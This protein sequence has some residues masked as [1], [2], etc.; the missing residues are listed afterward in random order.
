[1]P[2]GERLV[3][4]SAS[5]ILALF[6]L[7][8]RADATLV[9]FEWTP[10][11]I[12]LGADSLTTKVGTDKITHVIQCKIHQAGDIFF[13]IIGVND[14]PALKVDLVSV[15]SQAARAKGPVEEKMAS[16]EVLAKSQI[17]RV[18]RRGLTIQLG[19]AEQRIDIIFVDRK[20]H[21]LVLKEYVRNPDGS[22]S[23]LP[24][25][26]Y[27][28][29]GRARDVE[30]VGVS[31]EAEAALRK[32]PSLLK[33]QGADFI[34][35]FIQSQIDHERYRLRALQAMPRVGGRVCVLRIQ[36][37]VASWVSGHQGPCP[38]IKPGEAAQRDAEKN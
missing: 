12:L 7:P 11:E 30:A 13:T 33:L 22:T 19:F 38:D 8:F 34:V 4:G 23:G 1:M 17:Q 15:A 27:R 26:V 31:A 37:G 24:R 21:I 16:F 14:D 18:M 6:L 36:N 20:A 3:R 28:T 32:N 29:P 10:T 25:R 35:A 5:L 9:V 2:G